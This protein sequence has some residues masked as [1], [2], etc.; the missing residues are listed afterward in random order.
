LTPRQAARCD[1]LFIAVTTKDIVPVTRFDGNTISGGK[2]GELT[3]GLI[4][5]FKQLVR[6]KKR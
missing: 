4:E 6:S 2:C 1:E 3:A 5:E